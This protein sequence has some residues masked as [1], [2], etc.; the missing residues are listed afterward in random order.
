[1]ASTTSTDS[2]SWGTGN[3]LGVARAEADNDMLSRAFIETSDFR[4]LRNTD[5]FNFVVGRRG[6]GKTAL[7]LRSLEEFKND[8]KI[9]THRLKPEEHDSLALLSLLRRLGDGVEY[10]EIRA[11][12]RILWRGSILLCVA[13]DLCGHWKYRSN[14]DANWLKDYTDERKD[15]L[16]LNEIQRCVT[17]LEQLTTSTRSL[18]A[19]PGEIAA[20]L[21]ISRLEQEVRKGLE[22]VNM[23]SIFF[24]DGLDEGWLPD[25][26]STG[27]IGGLAS[28]V[29]DFK[30][31]ELS[32]HGVLFVRDNI[33]RS[34]AAFDTD[35]SRHIEGSTLRLHWSE[36]SLLNFIASRLRVV[37]DMSD[38]ENNNRVWNRFAHRELKNRE[39]F[40]ACLKYTLYRPRDVLVLLNGAAVHAS[41][42]GRS[43][44]VQ[45]DIDAR[46]KQ[47]SRDRFADLLKEYETVFPGLGIIA[48][49]F[50]GSDAFQSLES[51]RQRLDDM[52]SQENYSTPQSSDLA[53]LGTSS[54][55]IDALYSVGFLGLENLVTRTVR[56]C[57]D[58]ALSS[59]SATE[60]SRR[61]AI[62]PCYW[63]ALDVTDPAIDAEVVIDIHDDYETRFDPQVGD[64]RTKR[65][66]QLIS[67]LP[68]SGI[69]GA[70]DY[71]KWLLR[72]CQILF[73]G[74]L[75]N[76]QLHPNPD[77]VQR[78][79]VVAT[80][81]AER[82]FW[83]RIL[84]DYGVRQV[85]FEAK[86][87]DDLGPDDY[88][89]A[90]SYSGRQ[91]GQ[92]VFLVTRSDVL[93][94]DTTARGWV[95]EMWDQHGVLL[96]VL[97]TAILVQCLKKIRRP[98]NVRP[99][100]DRSLMK[101]LDTFER[102]Y[103]A[104]KHARRI[105]RRT[106]RSSRSK[107]P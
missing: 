91:F 69:E 77:S 74:E 95:K 24:F 68:S 82:G 51:V 70:Q 18:E 30:D 94:L 31:H 57:H 9:F 21:N 78:R 85:I 35:F 90:L 13:K 28:T 97:P 83:K 104:L 20:A 61:V 26:T 63:R 86:N 42:G 22:S 98:A 39:G 49:S 88:R 101:R 34:L 100:T 14:I 10:R 73:A 84:D 92:L 106:R 40:R 2:H 36:E 17:L 64:I 103:L 65:L 4:A 93:G 19:L 89:Q 38:V 12:T 81:G 29:A 41:R 53:I 43:E 102:D 15:L 79:D 71:E 59:I 23:R 44:I 62:H 16:T 37:L 46:S 52:L 58:G 27:V 55:L 32:V 99:Y 5:D 56:F 54:G 3:V 66:G 67:D 107:Q 33:F 7:F 87:Y 76:F 75:S 45:E 47:I 8:R 11:I 48:G 72:V 1:M 25:S 50:A 6:T 105:K 80:N 96:F 60:G